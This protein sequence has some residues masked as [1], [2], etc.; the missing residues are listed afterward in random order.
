MKKTVSIQI[1]GILF[2]IDDD[3]YAVLDTYLQ[4]IRAHFAS[5]ADSAEIVD[6]IERRIAERFSESLRPGKQTIGMPDVN[7]LIAT[8]GTVQDIAAFESDGGPSPAHAH[9]KEEESGPDESTAKEEQDEPRGGRRPRRLYRDPS[10]RVL[11]G[12]A[13]GIAT[14]FGIDPVI[15]RILFVVAAIL[16]HGIGILVYVILWIAVPEARTPTQ[17]M[18]MAGDPVTISGLR[19]NLDQSTRIYELKGFT[20]VRASGGIRILVREDKEYRVAARGTARDLESLQ[21]TVTGHELRIQRGN[22]SWFGFIFHGFRGLVIEISAP[23]MHSVHAE[24]AS[25]ADV[26]GFHGEKLELI[27]KGASKLRATTRAKHVRLEAEGASAVTLNGE[28]ESIHLRAAGA[29]SANASG[30]RAKRATFD[31]AGACSASV[32]ATESVDGHVTGASAG[33]YYGKPHTVTATA[34]GAS[35]LKGEQGVREPDYE[36]AYE[37][38]RKTPVLIRFF[39]KLVRGIF[40]IAGALVMTAA[41]L[42]LFVLLY[43]TVMTVKTGMLPFHLGS[44]GHSGYGP[45][46]LAV[47]FL[48]AFIPVLAVMAIGKIMARA[49]RPFHGGRFVGGLLGWSVV[50]A[51]LIALF[52]PPL[53]FYSTEPSYTTMTNLTNLAPAFEGVAA[54]GTDIVHITTG[55]TYQVIAQGE[56]KDLDNLRTG[57]K[58]GMLTFEHLERKKFCPFCRWHPMVFTVRMPAIARI[59]LDGVASVD[60]LVTSGSNMLTVH[61]DGASLLTL[62]GSGTLLDASTDGIAHLAAGGLNV[63]T[64]QVSVSGVSRIDLGT[65]NRITGSV[66]DV[67]RLTYHGRPSVLQVRSEDVSRIESRE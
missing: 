60:A 57:V 32:F 40:K 48:A 26:E 8:M 30:F 37:E 36:A 55:E 6:D 12:V 54:D 13:A 29:C 64:A 27:A 1:S 21:L 5:F 41:T 38:Y 59:D 11:G 15:V 31:V 22:K 35:S 46:V 63:D 16:L 17:R 62:F 65:A 7:A 66:K 45:F 49:G 44:I 28:G 34:S 33:K 58:D 19:E 23:V 39:R 20:S 47:F 42:A 25:Q 50:L 4:S 67:S 24:G 53:P 3:A 10:D 52:A 14:Y 43:V 18:E 61:L 9:T 2:H 51:A 56:Q